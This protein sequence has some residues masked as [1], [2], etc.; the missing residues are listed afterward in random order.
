MA[1]TSSPAPTTVQW[2]HRLLLVGTVVVMAVVT[3]ACDQEPRRFSSAASGS[4]SEPSPAAPP[5]RSSA[6]PAPKP[7][8]GGQP[9]T[10]GEADGVVP[11]GTTV[12]DDA[13]PAVAKLDPALL[14]A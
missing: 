6:A 5:S 8:R 1:R 10:V 2:M 7:H 11:D 12:F 13:I 4:A 3:T 14:T 9:A